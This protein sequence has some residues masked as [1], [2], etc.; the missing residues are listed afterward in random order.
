MNGLKTTLW[1]GLV[2]K[3]EGPTVPPSRTIPWSQPQA[4]SITSG[5]R[6]KSRDGTSGGVDDGRT[7]VDEKELHEDYQDNQDYDGE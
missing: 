1:A 7:R 6:R 3:Q 5:S 2:P 4:P